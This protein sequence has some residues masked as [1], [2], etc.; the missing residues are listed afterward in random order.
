M[1]PRVF[2]KL[3]KRLGSLSI[4]DVPP[5]V[6]EIFEM[7]GFSQLIDVQKRLREVSLVGCRGHLHRWQ[8]LRPI[9]WTTIRS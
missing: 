5:G 8:R 6:F 2:L 7:T 1:G 9:A 4:I 3:R